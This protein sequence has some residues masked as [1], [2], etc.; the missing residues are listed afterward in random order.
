MKGI[1]FAVPSRATVPL[2]SACFISL[3]LAGCG[4]SSSSDSDPG[5]GSSDPLIVEGGSGVLADDIET[6][7]LLRTAATGSS[8]YIGKNVT[9]VQRL[10][11]D[12]SSVG[13]LL[14]ATPLDALLAMTGSDPVS[15]DE[16]L[17]AGIEEDISSIIDSLMGLADDQTAVTRTGNRITIDPD[18]AAFCEREILDP[19]A[20]PTEIANCQTLV[21]QV[22][23]QMDAV[24]EDSGLVTITFA[25]QNLLLIGY[26]P[27]TVNYEVKL[28]GLQTLLE[29]SA[30]L[31]GSSDPVPDMQGAVRVSAT[32][33][34]DTLNAEAG[35]FSIKVTEALRIVDNAGTNVSL[36][37]STLMT[38]TA[39]A[40]TGTGSV[41]FSVGALNASS[42][43]DDG[44]G[45]VTNS[46]LAFSA[47]TARMDVANDGNTLQISNVG[48]GNGPLTLTVD[49]N[50]V[51]RLVMATLGS[52][53]DGDAGTIRLDTA[54]DVQLSMGQAG[55]IS[56]TAPSGTLFSQQA[57]GATQLTLGGPFILSAV[58]AQFNESLSIAAGECFAPEEGGN[59]ALPFAKVAC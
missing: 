29:Q 17:N 46:V 11:G 49:S 35:T 40:A 44:F 13:L 1:D 54:L 7:V 32:V 6:S 19:F 57:S 30:Q 55:T 48:I 5:T 22:L 42:T 53:I 39:D 10:G 3:L 52:T 38:V 21:S 34:N 31:E 43:T 14:D 56:L 28:P 23:V 41:E 47:L 25:Q 50:E 33:T 36:Q 12:S 27:V 16:V 26:S 37:P 18:D 58:G 45:G 2:L 8:S 51:L 4:G 9:S 24:T 59:T 20:T 15:P